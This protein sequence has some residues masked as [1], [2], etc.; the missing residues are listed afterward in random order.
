MS[1]GGVGTAWLPAQALRGA[2]LGGLAAGRGTVLWGGDGAG[3]GGTVLWG[4]DGAALVPSQLLP[5]APA[6]SRAPGAA[7]DVPGL[8]SVMCRCDNRE[9]S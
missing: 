1:C 3:G 5:R 8:S 7:G 4:G 2:G 9:G 6:L